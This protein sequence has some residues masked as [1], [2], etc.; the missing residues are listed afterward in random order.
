M[1]SKYGNKKTRGYDSKREAARAQELVLLLRFGEIKD[2]RE[3]VPIEL[4]P[5][6]GKERASFW[7]ADFI[8]VETATNE[9]IWEDC[10]GMRTALYILKRKMIRHRYGK[11]IRET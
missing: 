9:E 6:M 4:T 5:K 2:L 8:Y 3:Q 11:I 10:K 7:I 1:A